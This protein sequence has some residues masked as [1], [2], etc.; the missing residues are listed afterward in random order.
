MKAVKISGHQGDPRNQ[1]NE[2]SEPLQGLQSCAVTY[3]RQLEPGKGYRSSSHVCT[4]LTVR[5]D[6]LL[7]LGALEG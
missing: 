3:K 6:C 2:C 5:V 7:T 4:T 1:P